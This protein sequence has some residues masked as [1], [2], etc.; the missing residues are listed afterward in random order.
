ML[1]Y[2]ISVTIQRIS[3][4]PYRFLIFKLYPINRV[5]YQVAYLYIYSFI[6]DLSTTIPIYYLYSQYLPIIIYFLLDLDQNQTSSYIEL[7]KYYKDSLYIYSLPIIGSKLLIYL[8]KVEE[9]RVNLLYIV[10]IFISIFKN[11][12]DFRIVIQLIDTI[13][14]I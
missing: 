10:Q 4:I 3:I 13:L 9:F 7:I 5:Y 8:L 12:Q 1:P 6:S 11:L 14:D 2:D